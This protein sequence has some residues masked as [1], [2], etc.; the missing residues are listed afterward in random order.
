MTIQP[1]DLRRKS[2]TARVRHTR[3]ATMDASTPSTLSA[4]TSAAGASTGAPHPNGL[5]EFENVDN[6]ARD[7]SDEQAHCQ[8][9]DTNQ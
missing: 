1:S 7:R 8:R 5:A 2:T 6:V 9:G 3:T 4:N